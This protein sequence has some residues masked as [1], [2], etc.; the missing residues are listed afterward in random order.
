MEGKTRQ[1]IKY[2]IPVATFYSLQPALGTLM[3]FDEHSG[4]TGYLVRSL[5]YDSLD[6]RD[7]RD[8][9]DGLMEKRKV[10]MRTYDPH[11]QRANLEYKC[12]S[13]SNGMKLKLALDR[14]EIEAMVAGDYRFLLRREEPLAR[15]LHT[16]LVTGGY[17]PKTVVDYHRIAYKYP[18]SDTRITF[19]TDVSTSY[20]PEDFLLDAPPLIPLI[21]KDRGVLEVKYDDFLVSPLR[22]MLKPIDSWMMAN[23]K[24][25]QSRRYA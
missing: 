9:L 11:A 20:W 18:V 23:S 5:Y 21:P 3:T 16:K 17:R 7:L 10:R 25:A 24:Y 13:G 6:D 14:Q 22:G 4:S 15:T 2:V 8:K 1:E 12:K 19:D